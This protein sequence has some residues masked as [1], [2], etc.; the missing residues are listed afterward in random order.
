MKKLKV[1][2]FLYFIF[3]EAIFGQGIQRHR[4]KADLAGPFVQQASLAYEYRTGPHSSLECLIGFEPG[5]RADYD[6]FPGSWATH[7]TVVRENQYRNTPSY[8]IGVP[9]V[10]FL[11]ADTPLPEVPEQ[12]ASAYYFLEL[13]W[14]RYMMIGSTRRLAFFIHPGL[15]LTKYHFLLNKDIVVRLQ[16]WQTTTTVQQSPEL[17]YSQQTLSLYKQTR[18]MTPV[19]RLQAGAVLNTGFTWQFHRRWALEARSGIIGFWQTPKLGEG[20]LFLG[21]FRFRWSV[22]AAYCF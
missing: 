11:G 13:S 17:I 20:P 15:S 16:E 6:V 3:F 10:G 9:V 4:V 8:P 19:E 1:I 5:N 22:M 7:Y 2:C 21:N 12:V 14:R 18:T